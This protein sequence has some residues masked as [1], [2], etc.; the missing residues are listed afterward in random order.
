MSVYILEQPDMSG[1]FGAASTFSIVGSGQG[2]W[3]ILIV[4]IRYGWVGGI[5]VV[6]GGGVN[7]VRG[8]G[9]LSCMLHVD[10]RYKLKILAGYRLN[11]LF[12]W[13]YFTLSWFIPLIDSVWNIF[14]HVSE[15]STM[16][17]ENIIWVL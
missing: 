9:G 12:D 10:T 11:Q 6:R 8:E 2:H 13:I 17:N 15:R 16:H 1:L 5:I 3:G 14:M 7:R 4:P